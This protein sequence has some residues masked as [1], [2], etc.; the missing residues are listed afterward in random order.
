MIPG[1][2][3]TRSRMR[4]TNSGEGAVDFSPLVAAIL[5][6]SILVKLYMVLYNRRIGKR[7]QSAAMAAS[8][9]SRMSPLAGTSAWR[10]RMRRPG[11]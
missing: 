11:P 3:R 6:A 1:W 7:I 4:A 8:C 5:C 2:A 10:D 9:S